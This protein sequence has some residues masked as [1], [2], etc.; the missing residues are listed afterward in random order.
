MTKSH[1]SDDEDLDEMMSEAERDA[2]EDTWNRREIKDCSDLL[3]LGKTVLPRS[4]LQI[5]Y[6]S[7]YRE[8]IAFSNAAFYGNKLSVPV[9]HPENVIQNI[10]PI[11]VIRVDGSLCKSNQ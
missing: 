1:S 4:M 8:L 10:R 6:R 5:H 11:E 9:R 2:L 7:K 3:A